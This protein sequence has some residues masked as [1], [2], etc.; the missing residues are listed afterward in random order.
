VEN[1][2]GAVHPVIGDRL[3]LWPGTRVWL[4]EW[5][6]LSADCHL[7]IAICYQPPGNTVFHPQN[8]YTA[9]QSPRVMKARVFA[10]WPIGQIP[11]IVWAWKQS[12]L[13]HL[14]YLTGLHR[15]RY[16]SSR[17]SVVFSVWSGGRLLNRLLW[18]CA[19]PAAR[20]ADRIGTEME[21]S[22]RIRASSARCWWGTSRRSVD[23]EVR[24]GHFGPASAPLSPHR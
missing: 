7:L 6:R 2:G 13:R 24:Q 20:A 12:L 15:E 10:Q 11:V 22:G 16:N 23:K 18:V 21:W 9:G 3:I 1:I 14:W 5:M 17:Q 4:S 8:R 19:N